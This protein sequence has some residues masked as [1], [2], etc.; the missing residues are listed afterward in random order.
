MDIQEV[1]DI[2]QIK[3]TN[4]DKYIQQMLPLTIQF[5]KDYCGTDFLVNGVETLSS[6]V[7]IAIAKMIEFYMLQSGVASQGIS[8]LSTSFQTDIPLSILVLLKQYRKNGVKF[9]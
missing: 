3:H 1:K 8:R 7:K 6:G 9:L 2:L 5:A 4:Q